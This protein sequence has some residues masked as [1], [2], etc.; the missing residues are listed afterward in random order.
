MTCKFDTSL[1]AHI[2]M[3]RRIWVG[4][5][6][7]AR[8]ARA[9]PFELSGPAWLAV[10]FQSEDPA[11]EIRAAGGGIMCVRCLAYAASVH[12]SLFARLAAAADDAGAPPALPVCAMGLAVALM[13]SDALRLGDPE[14]ADRREAYWSMLEIE[15]EPTVSAAAVAGDAPVLT[16]PNTEA[17]SCSVGFFELFVFALR[18]LHTGFVSSGASLQDLDAVLD[19]TRNRLLTVLQAGPSSAQQLYELAGVH[20]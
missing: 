18:E 2:H 20:A 13:L 6:G 4:A 7:G 15:P 9:P 14:L 3:L 12:A 1:H 17:A 19:A 10:G 16:A 5:H 8:G 11:S